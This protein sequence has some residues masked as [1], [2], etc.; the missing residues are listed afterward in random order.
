MEHLAQSWERNHRLGQ[1][2]NVTVYRLL[3]KGVDQHIV[4]SQVVKHTVAEALTDVNSVCRKVDR[5][6]TKVEEI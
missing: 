6:I 1:T 5:P 3:T 2:K 4:N